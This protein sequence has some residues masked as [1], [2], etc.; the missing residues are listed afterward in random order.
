MLNATVFD[1]VVKGTKLGERSRQMAF[2]ILVLNRRPTDAGRDHGASRQAAKKAADRV[3]AEYIRSG[4]Y[5]SSWAVLTTALPTTYH[6]LIRYISEYAH[7]QEGLSMFDPAKR[8]PV[9]PEQLR[10]VLQGLLIDQQEI[11]QQ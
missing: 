11:S 10:E 2:D 4:N 5:P 3:M 7:H 9:I 8:P 1:H 6:D